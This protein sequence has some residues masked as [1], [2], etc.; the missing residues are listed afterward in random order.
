MNLRPTLLALGYAAIIVYASLYPLS[1]WQVAGVD[2]YGFLNGRWTTGAPRAD[3]L[4]NVLAYIPLGLLIALALQDRGSFTR[5]V[6]LTTLIGAVLSFFMEFLQQYLPARVPS[7]ADL[8]TNACGALLGALTASFLDEE[9]LPGK[10]LAQWRMQWVKPGRHFELGLIVVAAWALSQWVPGVPV[11]DLGK[12]RDSLAPLWRSAHNLSDFDLLQWGRYTFY[13]SGLALLV[14]TWGNPGRPA[15]PAFFLFVGCVFAYKIAVVGRQLSLEA[16]VGALSAMALTFLWLAL[17]VRTIATIAGLFLLSGLICAHFLPGQGSPQYLSHWTPLRGPIDHPALGL[18]SVLEILWPPAALGYLAR[19]AA[20]PELRRAVAWGGGAALAV[21]LVAMDWQA[22]SIP[23]R[24]VF[25]MAGT[26]T[27]FGSVWLE[28]SAQP[29]A[30]PKVLGRRTSPTGFL[31]WGTAVVAAA[32]FLPIPGDARS[33]TIHVGP[34]R[35]LSVPSAAA[36]VARDGD[37]IEIDAGLYAGDTAVWT[38]SRLTIRGV[39]GLAHLRADGAHAEAK[40]IW[41][42][43]G[44]NT[45]IEHVEFSGARVPDRN[46]AGIRLEGAGLTMRY[47][48]FHHNETGILTGANL[49]SDIVIEHSEFSHSMRPDGHSHN[50]YIGTVNSFTL[51]SSSV[52][53]ANLGHNVK[54]RALKNF[55]LHSRIMDER[56]GRSSYAIDFPDGGLAFVI[57]NLIQQGPLNDNRTVIAYGAEGLK[58]PLNELYFVNNTVVNDDR[59]GGRFLA[60]KPGTPRARIVNNI[61]A[62]PGELVVG[63]AELENN[64][65]M[66]MSDFVGAEDFDYRLKHGAAAIGRAVNP[67]V[68]HGMPLSPAA[69]YVHTARSRVRSGTLPRDLGA[70]QFDGTH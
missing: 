13:L 52:H 30:R 26:W 60:V 17:R 22:R 38:Q 48:R 40:A 64:T 32:L 65:R 41:V 44:A 29:V 55:I 35:Q 7:H 47:C 14:K 25:L 33:A 50:L 4:V 27:L 54:S 59:R 3:N 57:G 42:I 34:Q 70:L 69:Q 43:K 56:D 16:V 53:H 62:G 63:P 31:T 11:L 2:P 49:A 10:V 61:F 58:N 5:R 46:G 39:G 15:V 68:A 12:L 9:Q 28:R 18:G 67:G 45:T 23:F 20:P 6:I 51:R 21:L 8:A 24:T 66:A 37:L 19:I 1:G 36:K